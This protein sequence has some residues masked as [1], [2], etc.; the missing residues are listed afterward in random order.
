M[1]IKYLMMVFIRKKV[2]KGNIYY[3]IVE[4]KREGSK[5]HQKVLYYIGTI[6][7][8][9]KKLKIADEVLKQKKN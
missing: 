4:N 2:R 8:L 9:I 3:Y 1:P 7:T 5:V 6:K